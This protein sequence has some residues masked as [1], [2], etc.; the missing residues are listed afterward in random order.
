MN[1]REFSGK[2]LEDA[3]DSACAYFNTK[4]TY[5]EYEIIKKS[6]KT[7]DFGDRKIIIKAKPKIKQEVEIIQSP[8]PTENVKDPSMKKV[9]PKESL[10]KGAKGVVEHIES[11]M[12][13]TG[14]DFRLD[15]Y[16]D[17]DEIKVGIYGPEMKA[18]IQEDGVGID[19]INHIL[20]RILIKNKIN[21]KR[22]NIDINDY[23]LEKENYIKKLA[24]R[25]AEKARKSSK[26]VIVNPM[27]AYDRRIFHLEVEKIKGVSTKSLGDG[28]IKKIK[29]IP[30]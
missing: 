14:Y 25:L 17:K 4:A 30:T 11:L 8:E 23:R 9:T 7:P 28:Y 3:I 22:V 20:G 21:K 19:S 27:N 24:Q 2:S 18:L 15:I 12:Q 16:E 13:K 26:E 6:K 1:F 5:I 29:I 10:S